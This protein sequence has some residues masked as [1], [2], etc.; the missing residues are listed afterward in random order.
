MIKISFS[1]RGESKLTP[2]KV[3][4]IYFVF[5]LV[6]MDVINDLHKQIL[7]D[8]VVKIHWFRYLLVKKKLLRGESVSIKGVRIRIKGQK[9]VIA[10]S[11]ECRCCGVKPIGIEVAGDE[12]RFVT[13]WGGYRKSMLNIDHITPT[14][15]GGKNRRENLQVL[16][17]LCNVQ[18]GNRLISL[19]ELKKETEMDRPSLFWKMVRLYKVVFLKW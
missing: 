8:N 17:R 7:P 4:I 19:D 13:L 11:T 6:G 9:Q 18:K 15:L 12:V 2:T 16:C 1:A 10:R 14:S 5:N 3:S